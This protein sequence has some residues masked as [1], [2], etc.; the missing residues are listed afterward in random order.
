MPFRSRNNKNTSMVLPL[1]LS[2]SCFFSGE[3]LLAK[4]ADISSDL[5]PSLVCVGFFLLPLVISRDVLKVH[6]PSHFSEVDFDSP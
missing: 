3:L 6:V 4:L 5:K 1:F 2:L